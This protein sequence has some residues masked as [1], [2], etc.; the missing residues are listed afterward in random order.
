MAAPDIDVIRWGRERART[1]PWRGDRRVAL[2]TPLPGTPVPTLAFV[3]RC[4]DTLESQGFRGV[5]TG[6]LAPQE[7]RAFLAAGFSEAERLHLL[8][9]DLR[10]IPRIAPVDPPVRIRRAQTSERDTV[11]RIDAAAFPPFWQL[12]EQGLTDAIGATPRARFAVAIDEA[13]GRIEGY[14]VTGRSGRSGYLQ[15]LAVD[16]R[17]QGRRIGATL[18]VDG[19]RWLARWRAEGCVV[20]TQ[21]G[22]AGA[23]AL[24]ERLGF[25]RLPHGLAVLAAGDVDRVQRPR[26]A[27]GRRP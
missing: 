24:Y 12:D 15:R 27:T 3:R 7:Q 17:S 11:L 6:A 2:L 4:L 16:P 13:T 26:P 5:V 1:G 22:N 18:V 9:H 21:W 19:L 8:S 20:N 23:L 25:H 14:A 10:R